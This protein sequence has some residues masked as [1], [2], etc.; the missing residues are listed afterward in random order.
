MHKRL[1]RPMF[2][3]LHH[4]ACRDHLVPGHPERPE[5]V[6]MTLQHLRSSFPDAR[7]MEAPESNEDHWLL[8]HTKSHVD[9]FKA[10][11]D[12]AEKNQSL[13]HIDGDTVVTPRTRAAVSH[14]VGSMI[15]AID[16]IYKGEIR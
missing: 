13:E 1:V 16:G 12:K 14:A 6:A 4:P 9:S 11:C 10:L 8:F 15:A 7:F 5:R 2:T 3:V